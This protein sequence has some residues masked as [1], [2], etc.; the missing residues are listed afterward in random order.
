[1]T[2]TTTNT[3]RTGYDLLNYSDAEYIRPA[4]KEE[5]EA[6]IAQ[7]QVDGGGGVIR[8]D[9]LSCYAVES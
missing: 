3:D 4:T 6:S 7:A 9:G 8:I 1:M 5:Y 2:T